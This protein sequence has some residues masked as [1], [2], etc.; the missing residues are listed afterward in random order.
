MS[1]SCR[2]CAILRACDGKLARFRGQVNRNAFLLGCL[3][4]T[5]N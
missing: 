2:V 1:T 3:A 5:E 4:Y